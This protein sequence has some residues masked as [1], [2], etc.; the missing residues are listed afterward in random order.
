MYAEG[1][2]DGYAQAAMA[3][4]EDAD[5]CA[6]YMDGNEDYEYDR[7]YPDDGDLVEEA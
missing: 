5:Y 6:G 1:Y 3:H 4:I 7:D 2:V